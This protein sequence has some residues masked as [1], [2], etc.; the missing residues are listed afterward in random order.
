VVDAANLPWWAFAIGAVLAIAT[1]VLVSRE[2]E[3]I[4]RQPLD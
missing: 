3:V 1:S 2:P 4:S